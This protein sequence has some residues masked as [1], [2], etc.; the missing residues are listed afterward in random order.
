MVPAGTP[1]DVWRLQIGAIAKALNVILL[2]ALVLI[3]MN[4]EQTF[5][6]AVGTMR[7]R[8]KFVVLALVV[9]FGAR[10]YVRSQAILF[11][12]PDIALWSV[13]S[14]ALLIGCV[15]LIV[16]YARTRLAE[17]DVYPSSAVLRSSLTVLIVGG[18][19]FVVGV[20]ARWSGA[21][22]EPRSSSSRPLSCL[23]GMAGLAVLLLSDRARQR[24]HVFVV[25]HFRKAQHD[26]VRIWTLFSQRLASVTDQAGLCAVSA[27]LISETFDVLSVT[28]WLLDEEKEQLIVARLDGATIARSPAAPVPSDTASRA[29]AAGLQTMSS[30]FDLEDVQRAPGPR[31]CGNSIRRRSRTAATGCAFPCAPENELSACSC[32]PIASTARSTRSRNWSC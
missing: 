20:L 15:F 18:Y 24:I 5:R 32:W 7:W 27:K 28:V 3:L 17:I 6:S 23:L 9:I 13:E 25:R 30:P 22:A 26:S 4:L 31:N 21:L 8:I 11:S 19:L 1:G 10:L 29:V 14:G 12:A 16:A 2:V